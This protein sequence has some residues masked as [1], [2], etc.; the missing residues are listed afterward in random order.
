MAVLTIEGSGMAK[1]SWLLA[2]LAVVGALL[3]WH[4]SRQQPSPALLQWTD[5]AAVAAPPVGLDWD[6]VDAYPEVQEA[7][8]GTDPVR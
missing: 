3:V 5:V 7:I 6:R 8:E 4:Q 1:R 2:I